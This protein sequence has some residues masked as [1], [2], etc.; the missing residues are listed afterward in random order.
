MKAMLGLSAAG[1]LPRDMAI[2]LPG[3]ARRVRLAFEIALFFVAAPI[4]VSLVLKTFRLPLFL[5]LQPILLG[6]FIYLLWDPT[7]LLRRELARGFSLRDLLA[8]IGTF[9]VLGSAIA[10]AA[11]ILHPSGFFSFPYRL[12]RLWLTIMVLYPLMSVLAQEFVYRTFFFHRYGPLFGNARWAAIVANAA[13]FGFAHIIFN[14]LIAVAGSFFIGLLFAYRYDVTRSL[15]AVW[16]EHSLYGCLVF[17]V[18]L[19]RYFFTG[20]SI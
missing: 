3:L 5:V 20:I 2:V 4:L 15:W 12:P 9:L 13:L 8:I 6:F 16:L 11:H 19:G 1:T 17:T 7:F 18:G 10:Y 14:N